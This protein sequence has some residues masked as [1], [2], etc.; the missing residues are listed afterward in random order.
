MGLMFQLHEFDVSKGSPVGPESTSGSA[1]TSKGILEKAC[2]LKGFFGERSL[3]GILLPQVVLVCLTRFAP[4][5][6]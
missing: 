2:L 5:Q 6:I 1:R 3:Q 4:C